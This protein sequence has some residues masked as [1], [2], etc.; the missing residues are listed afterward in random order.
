VA[1]ALDAEHLD[2]IRDVRVVQED[3]SRVLLVDGTGDLTVERSATTARADL[4]TD[5][6]GGK[7]TFRM[8]GGHA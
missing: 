1:N 8:S 2:K 7:L 6:F 4:F 5:T 3:G